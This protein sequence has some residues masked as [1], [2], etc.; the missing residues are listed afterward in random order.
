MTTTGSVIHTQRSS[1]GTEPARASARK[2]LTSRQH[3]P[4]PR[5]PHSLLQHSAPPDTPPTRRFAAFPQRPTCH[6]GYRGSPPPA[7]PDPDPRPPQHSRGGGGGGGG[8]PG[9]SPHQHS[10]SAGGARAP[11]REASRPQPPP[12]GGRALQAGASLPTQQPRE[13][14]W[15]GMTQG[16]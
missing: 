16:A 3:S 2:K 7:A 9:A 8:V 1:S 13:A 4:C 5:T 15:G 11:A 12:P 10:G 14:G 6:E